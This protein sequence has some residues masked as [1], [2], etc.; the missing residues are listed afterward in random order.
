M[1]YTS[2]IATHY[3]IMICKE[4]IKKIANLPLYYLASKFN[5]LELVREMI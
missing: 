2:F 3:V 5:S 4:V 1:L